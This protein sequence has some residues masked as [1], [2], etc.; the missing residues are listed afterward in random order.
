MKWTAL[1]HQVVEL[2]GLV[3]FSWFVFVNSFAESPKRSKIGIALSGGSALGLA[4]IGVLQYFEE[5]RIPI[6]YLAGTSMGGLIGGFYASGLSAAEIET[7]AKQ[8]DWSDLINASPRFLDQPI[9]EKQYWNKP[10]GT[11][12]LR[13]GRRFALPSGISSGE[14]LYLLFSR[15]TAAYANLTTFDQLPIPFR[16]VATDLVSADAVVLDR[17]S[18]PKALRA[19]MALPGIFSPVEYDGRVLVDG[20]LVE[21]LPVE[22]TRDMGA[23]F[24]IAVMLEN[25]RA[26]TL[27]FRSLS[28]VLHQTIAIPIIQNERRSAALANIVI[29]VQ[30]GNLTG[31]DFEDSALLIQRGYEAA[32]AKAAELSPLALSPAQWERYLADRRKRIRRLPKYGTLVAV[33]SPQ[34]TIQRSAAHELFRRFGNKPLQTQ[35]LE[36]EIAGIT[37]ATGLPGA[38]YEWRSQSGVPAGYRVELLPRLSRLIAL[39]PELIA[40]FSPDE[41]IRPALGLGVTGL[42]LGTYKSRYVADLNLG[43]DPGIRAEYFHAFD[44]MGYFV[45]PGVSVQQYNYNVYSGTTRTV[46]QRLRAAGSFHAGTGTGRFTQFRVG[47]LAGY[48]SYSQ[49][50]TANGVTAESG[51]F[52]NLEAGWIHNTQDSGALPTKGT[53][54]E[55]SLGYSFRTNPFPFLI[56]RF[57]I[58]HPFNSRASFFFSTNQESTFGINPSFYD[59]FT[60]GGLGQLEAYRYQEFHAN[61]L[62]SASSGAVFHVG[63]TKLFSLDP[64]LTGLYEA[65]RLDLGSQGWQTHQSVSVGVLL[66]TPVGTLGLTVAVDEQQKLRVRLSIGRF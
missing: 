46:F 65:A 15:H 9:V 3:L 64:R 5:H 23:N 2:I 6:D 66:A 57:S 17:G 13:F 40:E 54:L 42:P 47:V 20:G 56:N 29:R 43:Y 28:G 31:I 41:P 59:Q 16:C 61:T 14:A 33:D 38:Y 52:A 19:T 55:G 63:K 18:L 44:G 62:I 25:K 10:S 39:R 4:H 34:P 60:Y 32:R 21:N 48:D 35:D 37:A 51:P 8:A 27:Q 53:L 22:A 12:T 1:N 11:L 30:T 36:Y 58:F 49:R 24:V 7:I 26:G 50:V 45:S